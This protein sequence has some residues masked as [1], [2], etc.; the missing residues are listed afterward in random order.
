MENTPNVLK[1]EYRVDSIKIDTHSS[2]EGFFY[3]EP[4]LTRTGIFDY[5]NPDGSIPDAGKR[6]RQ[7]RP[8]CRLSALR[9]R[10]GDVAV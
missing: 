7:H 3:D 4:I 5:K 8:C 10:R 2:R 1:G 9:P 6:L